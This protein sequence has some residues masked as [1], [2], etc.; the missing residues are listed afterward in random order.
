MR[1]AKLKSRSAAATAEKMRRGRIIGRLAAARSR[2]ETLQLL[3]RLGQGEDEHLVVGLQGLLAA[4]QQ[5][6][7]AA[8]DG[9]D[10]G[11]RGEAGLADAL[12]DDAAA[13]RDAEDHEALLAEVLQREVLG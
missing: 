6:L 7:V 2:E 13:L 10:V 8:H 9:R 5:D 4:R 12:P 1:K 11:L 3:H